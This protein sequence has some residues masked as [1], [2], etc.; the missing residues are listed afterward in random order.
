VSIPV[1]DN[2]FND[3]CNYLLSDDIKRINP[4]FFS[5][6]DAHADADADKVTCVYL[7]SLGTALDLRTSM[8]IPDS[9]S[10]DSV[11]VKWGHTDDLARRTEEHTRE[12][13]KI[14]G[15]NMRLKYFSFIA[16][17]YRKEAEAEIKEFFEELYPCRLP[18]KKYQ[19][20]AVV[21]KFG[22]KQVKGLFE[23][24]RSTHGKKVEILTRQF[25]TLQQKVEHLLIQNGLISDK[26]SIELELTKAAYEV[27]LESSKTEYEVRLESSKAIYA[28]EID[29]IKQKL[30]MERKIFELEIL[31]AKKI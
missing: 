6:L 8:N 13:G 23:R 4:S 15:V 25:E 17:E 16:A 10:D 2:I 12:Y 30:D 22:D 29:S 14:P 11:V 18:Y 9:I 1:H 24:I 21:N 28:L 31:L 5:S 19:E 3:G 20:L 7:F 27:R 26:A